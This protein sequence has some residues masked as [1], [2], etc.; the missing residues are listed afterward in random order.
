MIVVAGQK[1]LR[2][3]QTAPGALAGMRDLVAL[4]DRYPATTLVLAE[5][6]LHPAIYTDFLP[7]ADYDALLAAIESSACSQGV[8]FVRSAALAL[9]PDGIWKDSIHLN[10]RGAALFSAWL[11]EQTARALGTP[12]AAARPQG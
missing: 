1:S 12:H 3:Y 5:I 11:G 10:G 4:A 6:P 9:P 8:P 7:A 2:D